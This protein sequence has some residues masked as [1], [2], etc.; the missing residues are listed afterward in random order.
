VKALKNIQFYEIFY[1]IF[2]Q[3]KDFHMQKILAQVRI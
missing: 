2:A 1:D 3:A